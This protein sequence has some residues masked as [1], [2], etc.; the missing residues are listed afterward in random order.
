MTH[1]NPTFGRTYHLAN[2]DIDYDTDSPSYGHTA[3]YMGYD[4]VPDNEKLTG[5][6]GIGTWRLPQRPEECAEMLW[7]FW[8]I[9][10]PLSPVVGKGKA[11]REEGEDEH[12]ARLAGEVMDYLQGVWYRSVE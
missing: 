8:Y 3:R 4:P 2:L 10:G 1:Q 12:A 5:Q 9:P 11:R 6:D 7:R